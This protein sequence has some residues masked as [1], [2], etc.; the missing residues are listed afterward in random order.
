MFEQAAE[1]E[2][3]R[4][5]AIKWPGGGGRGAAGGQERETQ[6]RDSAARGSVCVAEGE[7]ERTQT[8]ARRSLCTNPSPPTQLCQ[9][10]LGKS[11]ELCPLLHRGDDRCQPE[12]LHST[13]GPL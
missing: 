13:A 5:P 7:A 11:E 2:M 12:C 10:T 9:G 6:G 4:Q 1:I 3:L 8:Q